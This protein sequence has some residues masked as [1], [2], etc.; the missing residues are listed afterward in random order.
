ME[1]T[2]KTKREKK[3]KKKGKRKRS[4]I[5]LRRKYTLIREGTAP[6]PLRYRNRRTDEKSGHTRWRLSD[7]VQI[8]RRGVGLG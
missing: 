5:K 4:E 3:K 2:K 1:Q 8:K 6:W 7:R